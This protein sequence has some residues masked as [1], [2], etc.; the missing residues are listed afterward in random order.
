MCGVSPTGRRAADRTAADHG[1]VTEPAC[2]LT[3]A[4]V[5]FLHL[6]SGVH[7][8]TPKELA[9][10][11]ARTAARDDFELAHALTLPAVAA[12]LGQSELEVAGMTTAGALYSHELAGDGPWWPDWQAHGGRPLPHLAAV[13][14]ALP[15]GTHPVTLRAF[16]ITPDPALRHDDVFVSPQ[17]WLLG[18]GDASPILE[19]AA[20]LG[21]QV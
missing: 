5:E 9:A 12:L 18:G 16:M 8:A 7:E 1:P 17:D 4:D 11:A 10:L 19:L 14:A 20:V 21:E 2:H 3:A 13:V 6:H 15:S